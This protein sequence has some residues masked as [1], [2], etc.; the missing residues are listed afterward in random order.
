[1]SN[2]AA[3]RESIYKGSSKDSMKYTKMELEEGTP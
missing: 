3:I 2:L 1:M